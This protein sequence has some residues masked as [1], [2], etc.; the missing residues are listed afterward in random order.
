LTKTVPFRD[1]TN[2]LDLSGGAKIR[3]ATKT[4]GFHSVRP[5]I[6]LADGG[7]FVGHRATDLSHEEPGPTI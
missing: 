7:M 2:L 5:V 4:S 3:W 1:K 6:K